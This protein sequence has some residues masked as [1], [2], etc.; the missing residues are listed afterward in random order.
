M[1]G[2]AGGLAGGLWA[3][4]D[5]QA[6]RGRVVRARR[7][8]FRPAHAREPRCRGRRGPTRR[9][10]PRGQGRHRD[11]DPG[12]AARRPRARDRRPL[13]ARRLDAR[14]LDLQEILEAGDEPAIEEAGAALAVRDRCATA[15]LDAVSTEIAVEANPPA[16]ACRAHPRAGLAARRSARTCGDRLPAR[17]EPRSPC[18]SRAGGLRTTLQA[19]A[20]RAGAHDRARARAGTSTCP[21]SSCHRR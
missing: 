12:A 7:R 15:R 14:I 11:R 21:A 1:T 19:R 20:E 16:R 17:S 13:R 18:C 10:Q 8:R 9:D 3:R 4:L 2:A 6:A 5:A